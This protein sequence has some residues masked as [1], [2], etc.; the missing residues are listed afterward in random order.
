MTEL[1]QRELLQ[2]LI[3]FYCGLAIMLLFEGRDQIIR[4]C[5]N[6]K[7]LAASVYLGMWICAAFLFWKFLYRASHGVLTIYEM[8]AVGA[9]ILLWKKVICGILKKK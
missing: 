6:R 8:I 4:R 5:G 7:R 1:I 3:M 2:F 9:G